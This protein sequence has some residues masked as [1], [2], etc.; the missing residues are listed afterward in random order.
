MS[1]L[2]FFNLQRSSDKWE[3]IIESSKTHGKALQTIKQAYDNYVNA[4]LDLQLD[5]GRSAKTEGYNLLQ[6]SNTSLPGACSSKS[7][8]SEEDMVKVKEREIENLEIEIQDAFSRNERL[9]ILLE[10]QK[11][12]QIEHSMS[13]E[14]IARAEM[15]QNDE[16][17]K[18]EIKVETLQ[19]KIERKVTGLQALV[20][21][22]KKFFVPISMY[23]RLQDCVKETEVDIQK[24]CKQNEFLEK[25][26]DDLEERL[27]DVLVETGM[28]SK[29]TKTLWRK[30]DTT[31]VN[32]T[33]SMP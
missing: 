16:I 33:L 13:P 19:T 2:S 20:E 30:V 26:M 25:N 17:R 5:S 28:R 8:T 6:R 14:D 12:I 18:N 11:S 32:D 27:D 21:Y 24:L 10:E 1:E 3:E 31:K 9:R 4:L 22:R 29:K 15:E 23:K 7:L